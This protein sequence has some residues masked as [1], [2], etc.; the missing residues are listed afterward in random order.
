MKTH[1]KCLPAAIAAL[2][3]LLSA[4]ASASDNGR[5]FGSSSCAAPGDPVTA[6][7]VNQYLK[8]LTPK[9]QRFLVQSTGDSA[10]PDAGREVLQNTGP[11]YLFPEDTAKQQTVLAMLTEKGPFPTLLV[12]YGGTEP[13]E[14]G[15]AVVHL[16][17]RFTT[18]D[19][20]GPAPS[21]ALYFEC[22]DNQWSFASS[23]DQKTT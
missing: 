7:A 1:S 3:V 5:S 23:A 19:N 21:K 6:E 12:L 16:G 9:P 14:G 2:A 4:C 15:R 17:G 20:P 13:A 18:G 11:T 10:L 8:D 22:K